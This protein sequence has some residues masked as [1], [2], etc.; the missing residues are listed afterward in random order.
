MFLI[1]LSVTFVMC[2]DKETVL[3]DDVHNHLSND[4][5]I[6]FY[7]TSSFAPEYNSGNNMERFRLTS[8]E[9]VG[10]G[11]LFSVSESD[12]LFVEIS[13]SY[14]LLNDTVM[15]FVEGVLRLP[16]KVTPDFLHRTLNFENIAPIPLPEFI[17][18]S[19]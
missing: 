12:T 13:Y 14:A 3:R 5:D 19:I 4:A 7:R 15:D 10:D 8:M 18:D 11:E 9:V 16:L 2:S 17:S 1:L 6:T